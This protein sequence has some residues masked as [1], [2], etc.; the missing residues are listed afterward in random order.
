MGNQVKIMV[1]N[2]PNCAATRIQRAESLLPMQS[3]PSVG[4]DLSSIIPLPERSP[5]PLQT[6]IHPV[7]ECSSPPPPGYIITPP[8]AASPEVVP[9][10]PSRPP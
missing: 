6:P 9:A 7:L 4:G 2:C 5:T 8:P 10:T 1:E 3:P